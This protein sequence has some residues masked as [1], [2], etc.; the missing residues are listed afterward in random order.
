[1]KRTSSIWLALLLSG[2]GM[3]S[4]AQSSLLPDY[5]VASYQYWFDTDNNV[6]NGGNYSDGKITF[7]LSSLDEGFHTL[8]IQV[9]TDKGILSP[10]SS[11]NFFRLQANNINQKEYTVKSVQYWFDDQTTQ[12]KQSAYTSGATTLDLSSL[13]EG[14]HVLH[15]QVI[16][17]KG[18]LSPVASAAFFRLTEKDVNKKDYAVKS[19]QYWFD[20]QTDQPKQSAYT[21]G[22][23]TLDLSSLD[24]GFHVLH[25]QVITDKGELSPVASAAFFRLTEK[26]INKKDYKVETVRYW[27]DKDINSKVETAYQSGILQLD[28]AKLKEGEHELYYQVVNDKGEISPTI[29]AVIDRRLY[30]IY[31]DNTTQYTQEIINAETL[32]QSKPD[33]KL[34][35]NNANTEKR[36]HLTLAENSTLSLGK[37]VQTANWGSVNDNNKYTKNGAT[38]YHPTTLINRGFMRA[39]SVIV[40]Q[41]L[42]AGK[43]HFLSLPFN[44][45]VK[46]IG[47]PENTYYAIRTYNGE[48]R[49]AGNMDDTWVNVQEEETMNAHQGY[50]VQ[51]VNETNDKNIEL[52]FKAKNDTK[53]NNIFTAG[54]VSIPL[55]EHLSEF[56]HNRSW[57][58]VGN[59]YP[60]FFDTRYIDAQGTITVWNGNGYSAYSLADDKYVLM[61]F[62]AFFVQ[63]PVDSNALA[64]NAEGRLN[65]A[66]DAA[67]SVNANSMA[68][69][70]NE[71]RKIYNFSLKNN[72]EETDRTRIVLNEHATLAYETNRD[73]AK[74]MENKPRVAQLFSVDAGV[75]YAI[76]ERPLNDG[77]SL[78]SVVIPQEG[79]YT[80]SLDNEEVTLID[81]ETGSK[82]LLDSNGYSFYA[83]AGTYNGRFIVSFDGDLTDIAQVN[84]SED[85]EVKVK[86][87]VLSFDY[88]APKNVKVYATDGRIFYHNTAVKSGKVTLSSGVNIVSINGVS[89]KVIVK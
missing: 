54:N 48:Q 85:G 67:E 19:V 87:N 44:V 3:V 2:N 84:A 16:T 35:Y 65:N 62:E 56:A 50:I 11:V 33:L 42:Y 69:R 57:N 12:P 64:F 15:Y 7:N 27:F 22:A 23:T 58:L 37:F 88:I 63:K 34:H 29:S 78:L 38:Y 28:L 18:E 59:L 6:I 4:L 10:T 39:D 80:L 76:N 71:A 47:M 46:N 8:H 86:D 49:A 89:T 13:D 26:D 52:I 75:K 43:W 17:D 25:Y 53:K 61:P 14:F 77:V 21:S 20:D 40:K 32:L 24:E 5:K 73:A 45:D 79:T 30:D 68:S 36:G 81:S 83:Q 9:L 70:R 41:T 51:L 55:E 72:D 60:S 82:V 66:A 74:F 31:I 1:M